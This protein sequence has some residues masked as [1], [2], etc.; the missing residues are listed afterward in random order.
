[1]RHEID[2]PEYDRGVDIG[3]WVVAFMLVLI[4][5]LLFIR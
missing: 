5:L 4:P 1:M 3:A 2:S